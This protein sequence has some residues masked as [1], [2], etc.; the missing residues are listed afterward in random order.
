MT[1][2]QFREARLALGLTQEKLGEII[3]MPQNAV[4]RIETGERSPTKQHAAT[5]KVLSDLASAGYQVGI[6]DGKCFITQKMEE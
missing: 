2:K 5:M 6:S 4:A 1:S 3:G